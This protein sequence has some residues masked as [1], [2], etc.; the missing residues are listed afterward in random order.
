MA[1]WIRHSMAVNIGLLICQFSHP[2]T[3][4]KSRS[5]YSCIWKNSLS[6]FTL[7]KFLPFGEKCELLDN[8]SK[9][10]FFLFF[11]RRGGLFETWT[12]TGCSPSLHYNVTVVAEHLMDRLLDPCRISNEVLK[13]FPPMGLQHHYTAPHCHATPHRI[14]K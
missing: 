9:I 13:T 11:R 7:T 1:L 12:R 6:C 4:T 2:G 10:F 5:S 3:I 14:Y 8:P